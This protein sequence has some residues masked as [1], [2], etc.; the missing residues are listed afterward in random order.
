MTSPRHDSKI[1]EP[2]EHTSGTTGRV[3]DFFM[4]G[5]P[6]SGTSS[7]YHYLIQHPSIFMT[8]P[9][10]P[11]FFYNRSSPG[12]PVLETKDLSSY[13][14]LF[15]GV[16]ERLQAGE[17][18]TSYLWL[19]NAAQE[20]H[21][22]QPRGRIIAVLRDPVERAY[23]Q[24]WQEVRLGQEHLSFEKALVEETERMHQGVWH[25][26][27][28]TECGRYASQLQRYLRLFGAERVRVYL[29][30]DLVSDPLGVCRDVFEFLEVFPE[31][32]VRVDRVY[33]SGGAPSS[34]LLARLFRA[35]KIKEPFKKLL[36]ESFR[37]DLG[38]RIRASNNKP[39]P[40][41][42]PETEAR[43]REAFQEEVLHLEELIGRDLSHWRS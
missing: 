7:L 14:S 40:E 19:A 31:T 12:A 29:F 8:D 28:Y 21:M 27:Y 5:A 22:L 16:P 38:D 18:S 32:P 23:S 24:Y 36:P 17:A 1:L 10:E 15:E 13:L 2:Q 3:P 35:Q 39:V 37:R 30:E 43:L 20:I 26:R 9:K 42:A 4:V 6:K 34:Q 41:M 33:N 11:H 25:G